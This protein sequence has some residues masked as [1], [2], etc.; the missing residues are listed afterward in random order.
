[1]S[2]SDRSRAAHG[3]HRTMPD[4][5]QA[6]SRG[7][8]RPNPGKGP[9]PYPDQDLVGFEVPGKRVSE[10][11]NQ[12]GGDG[13]LAGSRG[14]NFALSGKSPCSWERGSFQN[15]PDHGLALV[16]AN[17]PGSI[18]LWFYLQIDDGFRPPAGIMVRPFDRDQTG[19]DETFGPAQGLPVPCFFQA[20][21][22]PVFEWK[23]SAR[24][25]LAKSKSGAGNFPL[26]SES[27]GQPRTHS[28]FPAPSGPC[29]RMIVPGF[30]KGNK[31]AAW[32]RVSEASRQMTEA[33]DSAK[34]VIALQG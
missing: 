15:E 9:R 3:Q 10:G 28:D 14:E 31:R 22:I 24:Q 8:C 13:S 32:A 1:M 21:E 18:F 5:G 25:G 19:R 2:P 16:L 12:G 20:I 11:G 6:F 4:S 7:D 27:D 17:P 30:K 33:V 23:F 34:V 29:R 26:N